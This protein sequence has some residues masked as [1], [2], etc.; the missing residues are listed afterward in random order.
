[1]PIERLEYHDDTTF[2]FWE[3]Q[4]VGAKTLVR[5]G[6]VGTG[7]QN[8]V[9]THASPQAAQAEAERLVREKKGKG[10]VV[11]SPHQTTPKRITSSDAGAKA[12][13]LRKSAKKTS[14]KKTSAK[15]TSAKKKTAKRQR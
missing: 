5:Y 10:Y 14:A 6:R 4:V 7:G 9:K 3:V 12:A 8:V 13:S 11:Y 15:K 2:K 1:M